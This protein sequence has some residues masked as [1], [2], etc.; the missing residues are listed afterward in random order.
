MVTLA[1]VCE[2]QDHDLDSLF[3]KLVRGGPVTDPALIN[4]YRKYV[5]GQPLSISYSKLA[6]K[7]DNYLSRST[8]EAQ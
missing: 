7:I 8:S 6:E 5:I 2:D 3:S 1:D 4:E